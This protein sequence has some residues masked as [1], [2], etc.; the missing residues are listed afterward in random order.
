MNTLVTF[1]RSLSSISG[2]AIALATIALA[3]F[4]LGRSRTPDLLLGLLRALLTW[5]IAPFGYLRRLALELADF[6]A[7]PGPVEEHR[8]LYLLERFMTSQRAILLLAACVFVGSGLAGAW[9]AL[10]PDPGVLA[11]LKEVRAEAAILRTDLA[12]KEA[13]AQET[14]SQAEQRIADAVAVYRS[15]RLPAADRGR[16]EMDRLGQ[17][18]RSNP[19]TQVLL[20]YLETEIANAPPASADGVNSLYRRLNQRIERATWVGG[21]EGPLGQWLAAWRS[22]ALADLEL[23]SAESTVRAEFARKA[24]QLP[25]EIQSLRQRLEP[26]EER[27]SGL[28]AQNRPQWGLFALA[29]ATTLATFL[30]L[31][32]L[33]GLLLELLGSWIGVAADVRDLRSNLAA[34][35]AV[36]PAASGAS[37]SAPPLGG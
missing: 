17:E 23:R 27:L 3:L 34:G 28:E 13:E 35:A 7:R 16:V 9:F 24:K 2:A 18:M 33:F 36:P 14:A 21:S 22:R 37:N 4:L 5:L 25:R 31:V 20:Q 12:A 6:G 11:A 29:L 30:S 15:E 19:E 32:W 1:L 26:T 10:L 8:G